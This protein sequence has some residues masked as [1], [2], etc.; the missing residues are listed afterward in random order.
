V[1]TVPLLVP[2]VSV[3]ETRSPPFDWP[4]LGTNDFWW[5]DGLLVRNTAM[6]SSV[7]ELRVLQ[8]EYVAN[9]TK[10]GID[11]AFS[12]PIDASA[13]GD[14]QFKLL[15][16]FSVPL[17]G[18]PKRVDWGSGLIG[19]VVDAR[20]T[21]VTVRPSE[22]LHPGRFYAML[23]ANGTGLRDAQN[24]PLWRDVYGSTALMILGGVSA[25]DTVRARARFALP[26]PA[27]PTDRI[28]LTGAASNRGMTD[29]PPIVAWR[30]TQLSG[31]EVSFDRPDA[32]ST[33][34]QF[35]G[36]FPVT[37]TEVV[38]DLEVRNAEGEVD[39]D[40]IAIPV[41]P[42]TVGGTV[43]YVRTNPGSFIGLGAAR[44]YEAP[45]PGL[46]PSADARGF[47]I[48]LQTSPATS[49]SFAATF[50]FRMP[51]GQVLMPGTYTKRAWEEA[52]I[53]IEAGTNGV[54]ISMDGHSCTVPADWRVTVHEYAVDGSGNVLR[55][56]AD[57]D[58]QGVLNQCDNTW[59]YGGVRV[60]STRPLQ[61]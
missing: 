13:I 12:R 60:G 29:V 50:A 52:G 24:S 47:Q 26:D 17:D 37:P 53:V 6:V 34:M 38:V 51:I 46:V 18:E 10:P 56:D 30:W 49:S 11:L 45:V 21:R 31:P 9:G 4:Q 48:S 43:L 42:M 16:D 14:L 40:R 25:P 3:E 1:D 27:V 35:A 33:D 7:R 5:P 8:S 59:A 41:Q 58:L 55:L 39:H 54:Q 2:T 61:P 57:F 19:A 28:A 15:P 44:R 36:G 20:G 22:P 23:P 32:P